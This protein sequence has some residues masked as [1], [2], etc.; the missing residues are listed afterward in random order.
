MFFQP[1]MAYTKENFLRLSV[2]V[3]SMYA[4]T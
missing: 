4:Y 2:A 1:W 3:R